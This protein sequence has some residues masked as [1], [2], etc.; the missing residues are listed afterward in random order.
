MGYDG[1]KLNDRM[2]DSMVSMV[3]SDSNGLGYQIKIL[4][5]SRNVLDLAMHEIWGSDPMSMASL[6][7]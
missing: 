6:C 4:R 1:L 7:I 3:Y 5:K 2:L